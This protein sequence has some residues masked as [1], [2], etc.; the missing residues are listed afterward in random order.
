MADDVAKQIEAFQDEARV[1]AVLHGTGLV[2]FFY[3]YSGNEEFSLGI[4]VAVHI[5]IDPGAVKR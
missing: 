4:D 2:Q 5:R 3:R 1:F